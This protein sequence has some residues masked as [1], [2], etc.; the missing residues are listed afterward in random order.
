[1]AR[2]VV[3][4]PLAHLDRA[5][6]YTV[7]APMADRAR[8]GVRV[9]VRFAGQDV[10][11]FVVERVAGSEHE[12]RLM[13]LRRVVSGESVLTPEVLRLAR[14]V[15]DRYAGTLSDVLRLAVPPR[16]AEVEKRTDAA[17]P[18][19][20]GAGAGPS[21]DPAAGAGPLGG[22]PAGDAPSGP[23]GATERGPAP[24]VAEAA[25]AWAAYPA[26]PAFLHR[27]AAGEAPRAVWTALP[28]TA[29]IAGVV[30]AV[31]VT[32]RSGRGALVVVPDR[33]DADALEPALVAA[34]GPGRHARLEADLGPA[35]RYAGF[36]AALRGRV[37]VVLGT[38]AAAFAPV[39][40][41]GLVVLWD[42][43]D[44]LHAEPRAPY[45]HA[46]E[47]L[48]LRAEQAQAAMLLGGWS[49]T[50]EGAQ[51]VESGWARGIE[52]D[53]ASLR[54]RWARVA[55]SG[56]G[57]PGDAG[58]AAAVARIP[59]TAWRALRDGLRRGSVLVQVP[60]A[61]YL[62]GLACQ[63]CRRPARC[64]HCQ[65][66]LHLAGP[67]PAA[68]PSCGWCGR[69]AADWTCVHCSGR[70]L[71]ARAVGVDR[72]AE[73]LGRA[74]PGASVVV[75]RAERRLPRVPDRGGLVLATAG[76][77]PPAPEPGYAAAVLLDAE[78]PLERPDLRAAEEALRRWR[79]AAALVR[80][81][82]AEGLVVVCADPAA[83]A[84]Q[85]LVRSDPA[86]HAARELAERRELG[87]PP[88]VAA[89]SLTGPAGAVEGLQQALRLPE[90]TQVLGPVPIPGA[91]RS[92]AAGEV[93][94]P[95]VRVVLRTARARA[96]ALAEA[97]RAGQAVRS[98]RREPG[99]VRVRVDPRDLG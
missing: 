69:P 74:F 43:G 26:G 18:P 71:R 24:A 99:T 48:A 44:D 15:A 30:Q 9:R 67:G 29:W 31:A 10:D 54:R 21:G 57:Q 3:D 68:S 95:Q 1:M 72:T 19:G 41:L 92:S 25:D 33:R 27:L 16:H 12:G 34:L 70:R 93:E 7:P 20:P 4:V 8:A 91:P 55:V 56:A 58:N 53:R 46:R 82:Q 83:P 62:P 86:G 35:D 32:V 79:A 59:P 85:A 11:G 96:A 6:D 73:E 13:P 64:P 77:E 81:A 75:S 40:R 88:A 23:A 89:A 90:G 60:R 63:R 87:L 97:L 65:G 2:V 42:D 66:P 61:G 51:W 36:L 76:V 78:V 22:P 38:R 5:F 98:A 47:V 45:P 14:A 52:A 28:G 39:G 94:Q 17:P 37:P 50:A 49:R 84:V 80:P